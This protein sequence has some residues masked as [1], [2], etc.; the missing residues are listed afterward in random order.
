VGREA[1]KTELRR[2]MDRAVAGE[3]GL[4]LIGGEPGV[5][6]SRLSEELA[7]EAGGRFRV[8]VGHCYESGR[9]VPYMPWVEMI[10]TAMAET[11]SGEFRQALGAD[12]PEFARLVPEL[13]RLLPDIPPPI[14]VPPEQQ[15]RYTF[16]SI[17]DYVTRVSRAQPRFYVFEDLHWADEPTLLLLE[18]LAE[19]LPSIP[20]LVVGTYRDPPIEISPQ[21]AQT[22]SRLVRLR[23]ARLMSLARHSEDEVEALL[24]AL[25]GEAPPAGVR[26]TI[27]GETEGNAF[28]VEEVFRHLAESGRLL[29]DEGRFRP[30]IEIGELDVPANVRLVTGQR[31]ERLSETTQQTLGIA[32][33]AGR[34][35]GYELLEAVADVAGD[36]LIDALDEAERASLIVTRTSG[37]QEE[38]WFAHE[39]TRQTFL[40]RLPAARRRRHH[41]R[42]A[43]ALERVFSDDLP[44]QAGTIAQ[45]LVEAGSSADPTKL[46]GYLVMAGTASWCRARSGFVRPA[47]WRPWP[48]SAAGRSSSATRLGWVGPHGVGVGWRWPSSCGAT[49]RRPSPTPSRRKPSPFRPCSGATSGGCTSST[50][51]TPGD[52]RR[53]WPCGRRDDTSCPVPAS[54]AAG[55]PGSCSCPRSRA[56]SCWARGTRRPGSTPTSATASSAPG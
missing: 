39:L 10:E 37:Q 5:G 33:V 56:S 49:G 11:P 51:L 48:T 43:D 50:W 36:D 25:S 12:A 40:T 30:D 7:T 2:L 52:G 55:G 19:R 4:V 27:Y 29:D 9:D 13:R 8:L 44:A 23:R 15:R 41:L 34:H 46:F 54:R 38:Y 42:V 6:K 47:T 32:A 28:F 24:R 45:H 18:H 3:G 31:L 53:R 1:E 26:S 17:R 22:L 20:C 35:V 14:E 21:L 16:N